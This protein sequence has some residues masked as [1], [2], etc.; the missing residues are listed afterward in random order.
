ML[1]SSLS[2]SSVIPLARN[3]D[4]SCGSS[5]AS[6]RNRCETVSNSCPRGTDTLPSASGRLIQNGGYQC[7]NEPLAIASRPN[8]SGDLFYLARGRTR[9]KSD[10]AGADRIHLNR[11]ADGERQRLAVE[12]GVPEF[13]FVV[14]EP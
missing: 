4:G 9:Y 7:F 13:G 14:V 2:R 5:A 6:L 12:V 3:F 1:E 8:R 11:R 10:G